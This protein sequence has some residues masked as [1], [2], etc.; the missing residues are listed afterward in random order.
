MLVVA[1]PPIDGLRAATLLFPDYR[2]TV[3][4]T[5]GAGP[6][7]TRAIDAALAQGWVVS[8]AVDNDQAGDRRWPQVRALYPTAGAIVCDVP[9]STGKDWNDA[10][11][12]GAGQEQEKGQQDGRGDSPE[13]ERDRDN[14][15]D[16][17]RYLAQTPLILRGPGNATRHAKLRYTIHMNN[18]T[19]G[20][21][22]GHTYRFAI[23]R[24]ARGRGGRL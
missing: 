4:A 5:D 11:R 15:V 16:Q 14:K 2:T 7:P 21:R 18:S 20:K 3:A 23:E 24:D 9:P 10:L 12:A 13:R 17:K 8:C 6:L 19:T 22:A 1:E